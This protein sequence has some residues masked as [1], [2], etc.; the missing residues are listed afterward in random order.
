MISCDQH[1]LLE[2]ACMHSYR[3]QLS[4]VSGAVIEGVAYNTG[5]D[6][7]RWECLELRLEG[8]NKQVPLEDIV[9]IKALSDGAAFAVIRF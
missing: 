5:Y 1:D 3:L 8:G 2:L 9:I 6:E 7:R 4:L